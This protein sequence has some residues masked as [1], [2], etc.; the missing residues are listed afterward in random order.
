[1]FKRILK[2]GFNNFKRQGSL[3]FGNTFS[4]FLAIIV[5]VVLFTFNGFINYSIEEIEDQVDV[6][7]FFKEE[8]TKEEI[9]AFK[10][11]VEALE[12]VKS[13]V[14]VSK[15]Q[16]Y[17]SFVNNHEGDIYI[18]A[19][20]II[21]VNP[22]LPSI[23][24]TAQSPSQYG[25]ISDFIDSNEDIEDSIYK[26]DDFRRQEVI[27]KIESLSNNVKMMGIALIIFFSFLAILTTFNTV[28]LTIFSQRKEIDIMKL[29]GATNSFIR[30]PYIVQGILCGLVAALLS[31]SIIFA[32]LYLLNSSLAD[33]LM[34]FNAYEFYVSNIY[35]FF[36][37]Q[38][39]IGV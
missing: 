3:S 1:M 23:R 10:E 9:M 30:G 37:G 14:F 28:R 6:S 24:I 29:V 12:E 19:L 32:I 7:L 38:I 33:L 22:F 39:I 13:V 36:F 17:E 27:E 16:A 25:A 4:I 18:E 15:E 11:E 31:F 2:N 21:E 26:M 34:G 35:Q 20:K 5:A 8:V